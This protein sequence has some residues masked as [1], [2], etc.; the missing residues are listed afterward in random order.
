MT[1]GQHYL[2]EFALAQKA[3]SITGDLAG[4]LLSGGG[5][6]HRDHEY[7]QDRQQQLS[8]ETEHR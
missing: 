3:G 6:R 2:I 7:K 1:P 5:T 8:P 4:A